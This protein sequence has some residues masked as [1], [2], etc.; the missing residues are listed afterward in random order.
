MLPD[1]NPTKNYQVKGARQHS[2]VPGR[3]TSSSRSKP[4]AMCGGCTARQPMP[5][6]P[7]H[8]RARRL[9]VDASPGKTQRLHL[10][11]LLFKI[12][13]RIIAADKC[14]YINLVWCFR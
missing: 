9:I 1:T 3:L 6:L 10:D 2:I 11:Q 12:S 4:A 13:R 7:C 5:A 14:C 8:G